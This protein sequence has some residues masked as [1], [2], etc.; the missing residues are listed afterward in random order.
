MSFRLFIYYCAFCG[1]WAAL[2]GWAL[3]RFTT[4]Q[5]LGDLLETGLKGMFLGMMVALGVGLVDAL[6]TLSWQRVGLAAVRV[7]VGT[8]VGS[9]GGLVGGLLGQ[10]LYERTLW[11]AF[12][13]LGWTLTGLLVGLSVGIFDLLARLVQKE[14]LSGALR[15]VRNG[16]LGGAL[17]GTLGGSLYVLLH[18]VWG[19]VLQDKAAPVW[20]P[21]A[22]GFVALG[23]SIGL[24]I[25]LAQVIFKEAWVRVEKGFRPGRELLLSKPEVTIG[26]AEAC[27]IGLFGD[28]KIE[29]LHARILHQDGVYLLAA[30][31]ATFVN[32][33]AIARPVRLHSG[34]RIRVGGSVLRFGE[35]RKERR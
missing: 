29:R 7:G 26:R 11:T 13:I 35:R 6:G 14:E 27:D 17:G 34:D 28:P 16:V 22:M 9:A 20:S 10:L 2:L 21:S 24:L 12:L 5:R 31:G 4:S 19:R 18:Q 33:D 23:L 15:K 1:A 32:D 8:L 30:T 25:G 3:G